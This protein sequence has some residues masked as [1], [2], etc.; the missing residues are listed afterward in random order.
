MM[1]DSLDGSWTMASLEEEAK[2]A[3][4]GRKQAAGVQTWSEALAT[5]TGGVGFSRHQQ[6]GRN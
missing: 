2:A 3:G 1:T 6:W 4:A 5:F